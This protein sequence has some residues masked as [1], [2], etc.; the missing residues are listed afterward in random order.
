[1][2]PSCSRYGEMAKPS[3]EHVTVVD[4]AVALMTVGYISLVIVYRIPMLARMLNLPKSTR[5]RVR[6]GLPAGRRR[7]V[8]CRGRAKHI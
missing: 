4:I 5:H 8:N 1:M 6:V 7:A 3:L 2:V